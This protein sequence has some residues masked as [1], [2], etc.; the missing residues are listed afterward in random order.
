M[1]VGI[2]NQFN[3][4]HSQAKL[5]SAETMS[6]FVAGEIGRAYTKHGYDFMRK[7][8]VK[9]GM[10]A[11]LEQSAKVKR[12]N[13]AGIITTTIEIVLEYAAKNVQNPI[14]RT[15]CALAGKGV[16]FVGQVYQ[17]GGI[18]AVMG[19]PT[20]MVVGGLLGGG[21]WILCQVLGSC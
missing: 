4:G 12:C 8:F 20:G 18:G 17:M 11:T 1:A 19:G 10:L 15:G 5:Y 7:A 6:Q 21:V 9:E 2:L 14:I 3:D 13:T 16:G